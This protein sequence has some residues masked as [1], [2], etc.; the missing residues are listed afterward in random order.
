MYKV[1]E[2]QAGIAM[3]ITILSLKLIIYPAL[4]ARF[5][6]NDSYLSVILSILI[7]FSFVILTIS[8]I[9]RHPHKSIKQ[10]LDEGVG[11]FVS[12]ICLILLLVYFLSKSIFAV[13]ECHDFFFVLLYDDLDWLYFFIPI[14]ALAWF[15]MKKGIKAFSRTIEICWIVIL[16][17]L[18]TAVFM[19]LDIISV[20]N[21]L[22]VLENGVYPIFNATIRTNFCFGDYFILILFSGKINFET[23]SA[24][25][26]YGYVGLAYFIVI[27]FHIIFMGIFGDASVI[28]TLAVSDI[29]L[30]SQ[31]P[32]T[33]GRLEW[34]NIIIWTV[35]LILQFLMVMMCSKLCLEYIVP[36]KNENISIAIIELIVI[37][38]AYV[39]YF[40]FA[41]GIR[42]ILSPYFYFASLIIQVIVPI[43]LWIAS[44][45]VKKKEDK[46]QNKNSKEGG[47]EKT[48]ENSY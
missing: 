36:I 42:I 38:G 12:K 28:Q 23:K 46:Q 39:L 47:Y 3:F 44:S 26:I 33:N 21:F 45:I 2:R 41:K 15:V 37:V 13:K 35:T 31:V 30:Q 19:S 9:K 48:L 29:S 5:A 6:Q 14:L 43:I 11:K 34:L 27:A 10:I 17:G 24:K 40:S 20:D 32:L 4:V 16:F 18:I 7:D 1:T 25:K 22:P 8:I